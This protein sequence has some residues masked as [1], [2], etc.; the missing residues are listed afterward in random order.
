ME[1]NDKQLHIYLFSTHNHIVAFL[2][3]FSI[4]HQKISSVGLS[5]FLSDAIQY[6][7]KTM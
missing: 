7:M 4:F 3:R 6:N 2:K 1:R 5:T